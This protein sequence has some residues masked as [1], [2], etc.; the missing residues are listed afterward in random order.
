MKPSDRIEE[1]KNWFEQNYLDGD[2]IQDGQMLSSE[3][4]FESITASNHSL[5]SAILGEVEGM[6]NKYKGD[7]LIG[8][9][10]HLYPEAIHDISKIIKEALD[11]LEK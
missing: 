10:E 8:R 9:R 6:K 4:C 1:N 11:N 5:L 2:K 3:E 7:G